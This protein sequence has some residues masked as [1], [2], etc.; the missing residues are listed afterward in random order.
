MSMAGQK[1]LSR[2]R[3]RRE[4]MTGDVIGRVAAEFQP[5]Y[6][7]ALARAQAA[8]DRAANAAILAHTLQRIAVAKGVLS[9]D[10]QRVARECLTDLGIT[11]DLE[12]E[13]GFV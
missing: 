11:I 5:V 7:R 10:L 4:V 12:A 13:E 1:A 9:T 3:A 2:A 8:E 6:E